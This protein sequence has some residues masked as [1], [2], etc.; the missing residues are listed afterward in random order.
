MTSKKW[1]PDQ[2]PLKL[3]IF[4]GKEKKYEKGT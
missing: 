2:T 1:G 4:H 3:Q